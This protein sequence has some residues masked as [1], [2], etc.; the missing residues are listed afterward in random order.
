MREREELKERRR[1]RYLLVRIRFPDR[2]VL[3]VSRDP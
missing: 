2:L 3:Q 1:Y